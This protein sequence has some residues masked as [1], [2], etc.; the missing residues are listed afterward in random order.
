MNQV[1]FAGA[2]ALI[3]SACTTTQAPQVVALD[4]LNVTLPETASPT[5]PL[6]VDVRAGNLDTC[7]ATNHRLTL[8]SRTAQT[9]TLRAE[10]T[11]RYSDLPCPA[12][13]QI[14]TLSYTDSGTPTRVSPFEVIVNG[15]AWGKVEVQ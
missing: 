14:G 8:V 2:L 10:A 3:L 1:L 12:I 11:K 9:L 7:T 13:Y 15:K 5:E 6:R 4:V